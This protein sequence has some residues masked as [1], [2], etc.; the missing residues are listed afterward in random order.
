MAAGKLSPNVILGEE[1]AP[2]LDCILEALIRALRSEDH[3]IRYLQR[4]CETC[5]HELFG[6]LRKLSLVLSK[7]HGQVS[8]GFVES[9]SVLRVEFAMMADSDGGHFKEVKEKGL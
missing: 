8:K 9:V 4:L 6:P 7:A 2:E 5:P 1:V 3:S